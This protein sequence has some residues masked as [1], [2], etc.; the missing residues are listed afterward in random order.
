MKDQEDAPAFV[1]KASDVEDKCCGGQCCCQEG[2]T[3]DLC[4]QSS[5]L[6]EELLEEQFFLMYHLHMQPSEIDALPVYR[7]KWIISRFIHQKQSEK[8]LMEQLRRGPGAIS[9]DFLRE[10]ERSKNG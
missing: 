8:E 3:D 2:S 9:P 5:D 7:R 10:I 6:Q 1:E 4:E